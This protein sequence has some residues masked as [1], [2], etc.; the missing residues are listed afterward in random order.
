MTS[1]KNYLGNRLI[2]ER[3]NFFV[4]IP[5]ERDKFM[6]L[7]CGVCEKIMRTEMDEDAYEKFECCDSCS[8]FWAY[9]NKEKWKL[10][11][12]PSADEVVNKYKIDNT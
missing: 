8:T 11:W 12:R 10:G 5:K 7:F 6:P 2:S 9:P 4:I 3:D 1:W